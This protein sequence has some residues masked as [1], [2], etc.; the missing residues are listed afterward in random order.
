MKVEFQCGDTITIP[1][2]CTA[3][4]K[5]GNSNIRERREQRTGVQERRCHR[6]QDK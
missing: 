3:V 6:K 2:G 5:D 4:I 1:E